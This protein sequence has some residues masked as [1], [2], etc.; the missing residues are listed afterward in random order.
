M[1]VA[2]SLMDISEYRAAQTLFGKDVTTLAFRIQPGAQSRLSTVS[3]LT[4]VTIG[5]LADLP[6]LL[7]RVHR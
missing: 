6:K 4:V 3:G 1:I 5:E 7:R 2:G